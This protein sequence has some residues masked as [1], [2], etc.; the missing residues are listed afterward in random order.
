M[1]VTSEDRAA[2]RAYVHA[3]SVI[4][5]RLA[6]SGSVDGEH[7]EAVTRV[8]ARLV[9]TFTECSQA[10]TK[11]RPIDLRSKEPAR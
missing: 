5:N 3:V 11:T 1:T 4:E 2:A 7:G 8:L 6:I 9:T 10:L